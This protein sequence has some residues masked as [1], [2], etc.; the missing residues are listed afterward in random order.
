MKALAEAHRIIDCSL[1]DTVDNAHEN[2]RFCHRRGHVTTTLT[3][4][5]F[6]EQDDIHASRDFNRRPQSLALLDIVSLA[7]YFGVTKPATRSHL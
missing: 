2:H 1:H 5:R 7:G 6:E 4:L 3:S